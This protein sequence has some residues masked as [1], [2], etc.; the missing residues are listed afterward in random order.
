MGHGRLQYG[1]R[2]RG[3]G[4]QRIRTS[5]YKIR[6]NR[7]PRVE[8]DTRQ[9]GVPIYQASNQACSHRF[10]GKAAVIFEIWD[11]NPEVVD[12]PFVHEERAGTLDNMARASGDIKSR[13]PSPVFASVL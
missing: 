6:L 5:R 11:V 8:P 12:R 4:P 10:P 2:I 13:Q 9:Q 3:P 7:G 1:I